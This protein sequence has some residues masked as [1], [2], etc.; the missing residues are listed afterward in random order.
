MWSWFMSCPSAPLECNHFW[1]LVD[2]MAS[3]PRKINHI[4]PIYHWN[5]YLITDAIGNGPLTC[6]AQHDDVIKWKL[7]RA[8]GFLCGNSPAK[9][10][11][12]SQWHRALMF[13][14]TCAWT[15]GW[16]NT[17][18]TPVIWDAMAL[19]MTSLLWIILISIATISFSSRKRNRINS[20]PPG[21]NV[22]LADDILKCI[23]LNENDRIPIRIS[24]KFVPRSQS[25]NKPALV[26]VMANSCIIEHESV[27]LTS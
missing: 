13:T 6:C 26:Q 10:P 15:N 4:F 1:M 27:W 9:F 24:L 20:S 2:S 22:I 5:T 21:Q 17:I 16:V 7:F 11:H 19:I 18:E 25:D 8:T 3:M 14:V 12:K 23:F